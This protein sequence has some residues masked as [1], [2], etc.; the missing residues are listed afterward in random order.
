MRLARL[1]VAV[2]LVSSCSSSSPA[3]VHDHKTH[4]AGPTD[5]PDAPIAG[6]QGRV[7]Q[8][9]V[10]CP[11]SH[12]LDDDP[13]VYPGKPGE[14]HTHVF[15]G[16]E[17]A[18]AAS[19]Y[20]TLLAGAS[21]CDQQRDTASYWAPGL[22]DGKTLLI[23]H[24]SVAYYRPG[25][26][27]DPI[28]VQPY[29]PGLKM[30]AGNSGA[31]AP[32]STAVVAWTCGVGIER[33]ATP[34]TCSASRPLRMLVTFPDCWDGKNVDSDNHFSHVAYS[35]R[36]QCPPTHPVPVPQLQFSIA[37]D[38]AGDP[39]NLSLASGDMI[40]GHAD[41]FNSWDQAKLTSEVANC[42]HRRVVCGI[43]SAK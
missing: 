6:A 11:F 9:L 33:S 29:P 30:I 26:G 12:V 23:P 24:K 3:A 17:T 1:I 36:G 22:Y 18:N 35:H 41:F 27:V 7:P 8:F 13:I 4:A 38:F 31:V 42:L 14:S 5:A 40:T 28:L 19:T 10:E 39:T 25:A 20:D 15:F 21:N 43:T 37:Y 2:A 16:N 32:Q 34:P